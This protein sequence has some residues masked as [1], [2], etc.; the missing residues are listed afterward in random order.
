MY[1]TAHRVRKTKGGEG[2]INAFLY[3]HAPGDLAMSE[4][5][6]NIDEIA[7]GNT[8]RLALQI[9]NLPSGGNEVLSYLDVAADEE[10]PRER[11]V[12]A[13][14]R[15]AQ[16]LPRSLPAAERFGGVAVRFGP[17]LG[18]PWQHEEY[19]HLRDGILRMLRTVPPTT[20]TESHPEPFLIRATED[21]EGTT[22]ALDE[23]GARWLQALHLGMF[24]HARLGVTHESKSDF[25]RLVGDLHAEVAQA[26]TGLSL[27]Q[28][29]TLGGVRI[30]KDSTGE[31][32]WSRKV[33]IAASAPDHQ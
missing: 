4:A 2:A 3:I 28:I 31:E 17:K 20:P 5:G 32:V 30:V 23:G 13:L 27:D 24:A 18:T 6:P 1:A 33:G 12:A 21:E 26:L 15:F 7:S 25:Q 29:E 16:S 22:Y 19:A 10:T 14:S 11:I 9:E 8:G